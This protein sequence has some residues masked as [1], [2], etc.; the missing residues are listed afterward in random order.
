MRTPLIRASLALPLLFVA[1]TLEGSFNTANAQSTP[2]A[3]SAP[4]AD[5][6][7]VQIELS[8]KQIEGL[9]AAQKPIGDL[10]SKIPEDKRDE[11]DP[12]VQAD[13]DKIAQQFGFKN[14]AEFD[15]VG[16]NVSFIMDGFDPQTKTFVGH[17]TILKREI[18]EIAK[19]K[20]IATKDR[21]A[22]IKELKEALAGIEPVKFPGN[23]AL[24]TKY[25]DKLTAAL[26]E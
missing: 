16:G 13:L 23:I 1:M 3:Q 9:I 6:E 26:A 5:S 10:L 12:K 17:E 4:V 15:A 2:A 24:V 20:S 8:A 7:M 11:P 22:E 19:D 18:A 14:Y 21:D 25:Y